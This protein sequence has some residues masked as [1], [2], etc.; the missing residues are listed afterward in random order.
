MQ[1]EKVN[2]IKVKSIHSARSKNRVKIREAG[3][4]KSIPLKLKADTGA[5]VTVVKAE[6]LQFMHWI[7]ITSTNTLIK[8]YNGIV[9]PSIGKARVHL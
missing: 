5:N 7:Q 4:N 8:A 9:E 1:I 6:V 3:T 2:C